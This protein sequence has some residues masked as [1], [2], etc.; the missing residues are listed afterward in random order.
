M[1]GTA[2]TEM[3]PEMDKSDSDE[4]VGFKF[5]KPIPADEGSAMV[6]GEVGK[7]PDPPVPHDP[8]IRPG[9][10][11]G[12][13][14]HPGEEV[15]GSGSPGID[16]VSKIDS[17]T[18]EGELREPAIGEEVS[19]PGSPGIDQVSKIDSFTKEG[20]L[21]EPVM[22]ED[23]PDLKAPPISE[24]SEERGY[25]KQIDEL[26]KD[27]A[28]LEGQEEISKD[29]AYLEASELDITDADSSPPEDVE[30]NQGV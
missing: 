16:Q 21:R 15:S 7:E 2:P 25:V 28:Y 30:N 14:F 1:V 8:D 18:K 9:E 4:T 19:G 26:S 11:V 6:K 23:M 12:M 10:V 17:F 13:K 29:P 20:E 5:Y 3:P 22:G 24:L 27:P